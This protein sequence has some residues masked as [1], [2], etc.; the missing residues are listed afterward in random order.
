MPKKKRKKVQ[1]SVHMYQ[2]TW[3]YIDAMC[4]LGLRKASQEIEYIISVVRKQREKSHEDAIRLATQ[5][6]PQQKTPT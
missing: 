2:E 3:D 4:E 1:R 6:S 5:N